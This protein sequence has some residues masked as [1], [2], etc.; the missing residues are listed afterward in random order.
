MRACAS[1]YTLDKAASHVPPLQ[2]LAL[3][4]SIPVQPPT[5]F[6]TPCA[7]LSQ[8]QRPLFTPRNRFQDPHCGYRRQEDQTASLVSECPRLPHLPLITLFLLLCF[9]SLLSPSVSP[10]TSDH[11]RHLT[12]WSF[13]LSSCLLSCFQLFCNSSLSQLQSI[14]ILPTNV[15]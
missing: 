2:T 1:F 4:H 7:H 5:H 10:S 13:H 12:Q 9:I 8:L 6:Y 3:P 15:R 11:L 14:L